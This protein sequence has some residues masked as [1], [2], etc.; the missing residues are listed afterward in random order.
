VTQGEWYQSLGGPKSVVQWLQNQGIDV[1][2]YGYYYGN[3]P[4]TEGTEIKG[5][6]G[7]FGKH[8]I[9]VEAEFDNNSAKMQSLIDAIGTLS[10]NEQLYVS[11]WAN[12]VTHGWMDNLKLLDPI[13]SVW[14]PQC[15]DDSLTKE[16]YAQWPTTM[17]SIQPTFHV[18][19]TGYINA[20][21]YVQPGFSVWEYQLG[22]SN[23]GLLQQFILTSKGLNVSSYPTNDKGMVINACQVTQFQPQHSEF[24]CGAFS[25]VIAAKSSPPDV[26]NPQNPADLIWWAEQ[27]YAKTAG[28]NGP[29]NTAGASIDN[30]H[31][32]LKDTQSTVTP[33]N[34]WDM[35]ISTT[36]Q[37]AHDIASI[38][39]ALRHGY[40]V[41]ATV[42]E[43]SVIDMD[44]GK[45]PYW[46]GPSGTHIIVW[47]GI[48]PD[49]NL[50]ACDPANVVQGD[51]NL[52]TPKQVQAWPRKYDIRPIDN[53]WA[54]IVRQ[55]WLPPIPSGDPLTWPAYV[56]P[57]PPAPVPT[58]TPVPASVAVS[59]MYDESAKQIIFVGPNNKALLRIDV[60]V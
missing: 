12:P 58:P 39:A 35:D 37:Q 60:V 46:W 52:Q 21:S 32:M 40:C 33:L 38:K 15:Y 54:T 16:M 49:G 6:L 53:Q 57:T 14:M 56:A 29:A 51:G 10:N 3:D 41:I 7:Q 42:S 26:A 23:P 50:L 55:P 48:A 5:L 1:L 43:Q 36:S 45:N 27:E 18:Q 2:T 25:V 59:V 22:V 4:K 24:E 13:T 11:T 19:N 31:T 28:D 8:C 9:D 47:V 44:L 17:K 30:V 34:Y 20:K